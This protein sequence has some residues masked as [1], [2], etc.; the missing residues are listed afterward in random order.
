MK[1]LRTIT[2]LGGPHDRQEHELVDPFDM[3]V[4]PASILLPVDADADPENWDAPRAK[5][6]RDDAGVYR[7]AGMKQMR[8]PRQ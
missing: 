1:V 8:G 2:L 7:Y 3:G 4:E 5:Y 6:D